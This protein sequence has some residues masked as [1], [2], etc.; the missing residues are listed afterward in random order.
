MEN[1][2]KQ[3]LINLIKNAI[4]ASPSGGEVMIKAALIDETSINIK[5]IDQGHG[6]PK[7]FL[8]KLGTPFYTTKEKGTGL[9]LMTTIKIIQEH[10]GTIE[11]VSEPNSGTTVEIRLPVVNG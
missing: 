4:E 10:N 2:L 6:I 11:F 8:D 3:V 7:E 9:G 5:I 1:Q